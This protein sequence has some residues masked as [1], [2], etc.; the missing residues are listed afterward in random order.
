MT[1]RPP[2]PFVELP[3]A[4]PAPGDATGAAPD[5]AETVPAAPARGFF[6]FADSSLRGLP[7]AYWCLFAYLFFVTTCFDEEWPSIGRFRPRLLLGSVALLVAGLRFLLAGRPR[8]AVAPEHRATT[9]ALV[10]F[11]AGGLLSMLWAFE[12]GI[13]QDAQIEHTT[14]ML[15][16]FLM[17]AIVRTRRELVVTLLVLAAGMGL[18]LVRSFTEF[19]SGKYQ[20]TMGVVRMMGAGRS[21]SDP[22]SF[23]GTIAFSMPLLV[24]CAV[25]TRSAFL[26]FCVLCYGLL[27]TY[28][29]IQTHSRSGL[30]L[31]V[32]NL[33]FAFVM[34]PGRGTRI[35]MAAVVAGMLGWLATGQTDEAMERYS[36]IL[37][38]KTYKSESSTVGRIE[39][40]RVAWRMFSE[41]PLTGVGP[42]CWSTYR[43][44]RVDGDQLMPHN[45]TG[46]VIA[47]FG[48][49]GTVPFVAYLGATFLFAWRV[50]RRRKGSK[51]PWDRAVAS[52][53]LVV[54]MTT[55]L[56]LISGLGAHN[57]DRLAWYLLPG[58]LACAARARDAEAR[59]ATEP[60]R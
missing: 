50:R 21:I 55:V 57:V 9:N 44:R 30:V 58:L 31:H 52:F 41:N 7:G 29:V 45:L 40:Y 47:T 49:A 13:A 14:T 19:L 1:S 32:L 22:N 51:D 10:A 28:C 17:L 24:W 11:V 43:M 18:Y 48:L 53:A 37:S 3:A 6:A 42:G 46:Q 26:R 5:A 16:Y 12:P 8:G 27:A 34:L 56:L 2:A 39:G 4:A 25:K 33:V 54:P 35:A 23:A 20:F 60:A 38:S 15:V 36:S 59:L